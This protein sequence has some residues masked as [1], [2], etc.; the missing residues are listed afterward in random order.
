VSLLG[1]P[2]FSNYS[3]LV[4]HPVD[5][6]DRHLLAHELI[7]IHSLVFRARLRE[8][9]GHGDP[10]CVKSESGSGIF[11]GEEFHRNRVFVSELFF[12]LILKGSLILE[13][14][15]FFAL[16]YISARYP[17]LKKTELG[18]SQTNATYIA[19]FRKM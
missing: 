3:F 4:N 9:G 10:R 18:R 11:P 14:P 1:P 2:N 15:A 6:D 7:P 16:N 17:V 12:Y 8:G 5:R 19:H 13:S